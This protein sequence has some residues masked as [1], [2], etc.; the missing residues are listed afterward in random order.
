MPKGEVE[1]YYDAILMM[2]FEIASLV[3]KAIANEILEKLANALFSEN[4]ELTK[5]K[6]DGAL[7]II[8][9][10]SPLRERVRELMGSNNLGATR[11]SEFK[12]TSGEAMYVQ[13]DTK[14]CWLV[15]PS[16]G[17]RV[18]DYEIS[19]GERRLCLKH[20]VHFVQEK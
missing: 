4:E 5:T 2:S 12:K 7:L 19:T 1:N 9:D 13:L 14:G 8:R 18:W 6:I 11:D 17:E 20:R 15:C 16:G 3:D 10:Y